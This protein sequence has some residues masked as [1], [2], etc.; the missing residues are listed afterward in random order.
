MK[1]PEKFASTLK[2]IKRSSFTA[3]SMFF[4]GALFL[5]FSISFLL[6]SCGTDI[7][8]ANGGYRL[9]NLYGYE[10][11]TNDVSIWCR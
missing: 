3:S 6:I 2:P 10:C 9:T 5:I 4:L 11:I 7:A 1:C 8:E